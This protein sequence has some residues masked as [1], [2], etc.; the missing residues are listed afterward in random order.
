MLRYLHRRP[1]WW[2]WTLLAAWVMSSVGAVVIVS[3]F[4]G[5]SV[6]TFA[7]ASLAAL[8]WLMVLVGVSLRS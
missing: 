5:W 6:T 3:I 4:L 7:I 2:Q 8:I 1:L